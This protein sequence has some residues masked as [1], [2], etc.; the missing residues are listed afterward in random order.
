MRTEWRCH[1]GCPQPR[2]LPRQKP[3]ES[4]RE[5]G[6]ALW[7]VLV[8]DAEPCPNPY[9]EQHT[10]MPHGYPPC[11]ACHGLRAVPVGGSIHECRH[12]ECCLGFGPAAVVAWIKGE[13]D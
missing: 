6:S 2:L 5:C 13:E 4:C 7:R 3:L 8:V 12:H 9:C 1:S 11:Q 10:T